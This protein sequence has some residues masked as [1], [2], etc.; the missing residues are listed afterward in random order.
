VL[1]Y[2]KAGPVN[3]CDQRLMGVARTHGKSPDETAHE[4]E[5][6]FLTAAQHA[7]MGW[8]HVFRL[9]QQINRMKAT[10][11]PTQDVEL[12]LEVLLSTLAT[13]DRH[14]RALRGIFAST[15]IRPMLH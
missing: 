8:E 13:L 9:R 6:L 10:G 4:E 14:E 7:A 5:C 11:C 2:I 1:I 15:G 12:T 3:R